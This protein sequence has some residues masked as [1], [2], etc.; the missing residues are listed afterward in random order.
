MSAHIETTDY[1]EQPLRARWHSNRL[2]E[3]VIYGVLLLLGIISLLPIWHTVNA[4][5]RQP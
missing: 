4:S 1:E 5:L 2:A 3:T